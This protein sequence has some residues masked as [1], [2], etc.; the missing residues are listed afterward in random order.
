MRNQK[1]LEKCRLYPL[2][3]FFSL[4]T[5]VST[6]LLFWNCF[7]ESHQWVAVCQLSSSRNMTFD[8]IVYFLLK[9]LFLFASV[10]LLLLWNR[11]LLLISFLH[12]YHKHWYAVFLTW[13]FF[14]NN[15]TR[16]H[17]HTKWTKLHVS[18]EDTANWFWQFS[19]ISDAILR[20][21]KN[22]LGNH[23][24]IRVHIWE[25]NLFSTPVLYIHL[26]WAHL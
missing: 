12:S 11:L 15:T 8:T 16:N 24:T 23:Q 3:Y 2:P 7:Q 10:M 25:E 9:T 21:L 5:E 17:E 19:L 14:F 4:C 26:R 13:S 22:A 6:S 20:I 1:F 18:I